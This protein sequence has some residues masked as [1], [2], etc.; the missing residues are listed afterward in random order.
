MVLWESLAAEVYWI[1]SWERWFQVDKV[2]EARGFGDL[3]CGRIAVVSA[4]IFQA[5]GKI[6]YAEYLPGVSFSVFVFFSFLFTA[7]FFLLLS[8]GGRFPR[9]NFDLLCLNLLTA[10]TFLSFYFALKLV[11]PAVVGAIEIGVIPLAY[12]AFS[13]MLS[14][15]IPSFGKA[16]VCCGIF[17]GCVVLA[18]SAWQ[19]GEPESVLSG[20]LCSFLA[21]LGALA[22]TLVSKRLFA[23]GWS[24]SGILAH[25]FYI[26]VPLAFV[27]S[28][29][30]GG[31]G[32]LF[33]DGM[34]FARL[35]LVGVLGVTLPL[36]LLQVGIARCD[37]LVVVISMAS[38]PV[39]TYVFEMFFSAWQ[40]SWGTAAGVLIVTFFVALEPFL[41]AQG[42][43]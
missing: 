20:V 11:E 37:P 25:R 28:L 39:I 32:H 24:A 6:A 22:I 12:V 30:T 26:I 8:G 40:W 38:L 35:I 2:K 1:V 23:S 19:R 7:T 29:F 16:L 18:V 21:G 10:F 34:L 13:S 4:M 42:R 33:S 3:F 27:I 5:M 9:L 14:G 31:F 43:K 15:R 17:S 41:S 36:Y